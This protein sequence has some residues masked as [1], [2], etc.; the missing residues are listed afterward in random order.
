[1]PSFI[2]NYYDQQK[3]AGK[4]ARSVAV[5]NAP[6]ERQAARILRDDTCFFLYLH[7]LEISYVSLRIDK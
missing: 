1:M 3:T 4:P 5:G 2:F 7:I 6:K